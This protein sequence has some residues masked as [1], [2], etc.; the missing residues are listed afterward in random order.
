MKKLIVNA[1]DYGRTPSVSAGIRHAHLHGLVTS[2]TAM[3]NMPR[4]AEDLRLAL[5]ECPALG[6]GVHLTLT[7]ES[8]VLPPEQVPSLVGLAD[9]KHF[10]TQAQL[11]VGARQ[12][13]VAEVKA[14]W[15]A[16][17]S[18]F[19]RVTGRAPT[20]LDSHHHTSYFSPA[21]FRAML[22]LARE[23]KC[24]IRWPIPLADPA[25]DLLDGVS[26][27]AF[28]RA[29]AFLREALA[30]APD[31]P[32]P[33]AFE[34]RFYGESVSSATLHHLI[35]ELPEGT[36]ELMSHPGFVDDELQRGSSY[37]ITREQEIAALTDPAVLAWVAEQGVQRISFA[38]L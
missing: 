20:H 32:H 2:T 36:T 35:A 26:P 31:I 12:V 4:V 21:L 18:A 30:A 9:G 19:V 13:N 37:N 8:P 38:G 3:M 17:I 27:T 24:G 15:H 25:Q 28:A 16:Q 14:E 22:E 33:D 29:Q 5:A 1:D 6:L 7:A 23:F 11:N 34:P 10:P